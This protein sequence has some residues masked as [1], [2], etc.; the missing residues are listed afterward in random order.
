[1]G[2]TPSTFSEQAIHDNK[3]V[4]RFNKMS[5]RTICCRSQLRCEKW[6][7]PSIKKL[8]TMITNPL[9]TS[10]EDIYEDSI[11]DR[12]EIVIDIKAKSKR[13]AE[14]ISCVV[15]SIH[16]TQLYSHMSICEWRKKESDRK[17]IIKV[18]VLITELDVFS[19]TA[20]QG[21]I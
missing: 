6:R 2:R 11:N 15:N 5:N 8:Q 12:G 17:C 9:N 16:L 20:I 13:G 7:I 10:Y 3:S 18:K 14:K 4:A 1:M 21:F 19:V